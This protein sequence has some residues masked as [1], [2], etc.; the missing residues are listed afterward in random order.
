MKKSKEK[1]MKAVRITRTEKRRKPKGGY[2][3]LELLYCEICGELSIR[4]NTDRYNL[5][6]PKCK[7]QKKEIN[8]KKE[9]LLQEIFSLNSL[10]YVTHKNDKRNTIKKEENTLLS[11]FRETRFKS[12]LDTLVQDYWFKPHSKYI[13]PR[14]IESSIDN[15]GQRLLANETFMLMLKL[16]YD[17][18]YERY[19]KEEK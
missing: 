13:V 9:T 12:T 1:Q 11:S 14:K 19:I 3:S 7:N 17:L 8:K 16:C 6:C 15:R 2:N 10:L 5:P 4:F 18:A